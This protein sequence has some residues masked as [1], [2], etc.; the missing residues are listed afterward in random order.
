MTLISVLAANLFEVTFEK[1]W[2]FLDDRSNKVTCDV[3]PKDNR[4]QLHG[5]IVGKMKQKL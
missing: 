5:T 1:L 4:D 3:K 2:G